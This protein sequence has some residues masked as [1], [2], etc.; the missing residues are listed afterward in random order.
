MTA[1]DGS[2]AC[3]DFCPRAHT[4]ECLA[5]HSSEVCTSARQH[6]AAHRTRRSGGG[7]GVKRD[8]AVKREERASGGG[9]V[10]SGETTPRVERREVVARARAETEDKRRPNEIDDFAHSFRNHAPFVPST[11]E[12]ATMM[13]DGEETSAR[14]HQT[15]ARAASCRSTRPSIPGEGREARAGIVN[16]RSTSGLRPERRR[17]CRSHASGS[18]PSRLLS[19]KGSSSELSWR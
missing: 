10:V 8:G 7:G 1:R 12:D 16:C 14:E 6:A 18:A 19:Q 3:C 17:P 13:D 9:A 15:N 4:R 2:V 5:R 11:D